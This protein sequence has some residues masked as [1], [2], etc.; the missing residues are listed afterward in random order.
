MAVDFKRNLLNNKNFDFV[1]EIL[2][3][4]WLIKK[5]LSNKVSNQVIDDI[6]KESIIAGASGGK[7]IGSGGGGFLLMYCKQKN[8]LSLRKKLNKLPI[9][10]FNFVEKGSEIIFKS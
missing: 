2:N 1:G 7:I 10:K 9:I 4:Y 8:H 3:E 5:D 6:Y